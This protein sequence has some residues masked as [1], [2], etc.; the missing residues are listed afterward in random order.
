MM[1]IDATDAAGLRAVLR[2]DLDAI[3]RLEEH[4]ASLVQPA[5]EPLDRA[6]IDSLGFTLHN[7]YNALENSFTQ[8]SLSFENHIKD[9]VRWQRE[10]LDKMF[11]SIPPVRPAVLPPEVRPLLGDLLAFRHL[12]RHAY[13]LSLDEAKVIALAR[14]WRDEGGEVK[15][16]LQRFLEQLP[17][18]PS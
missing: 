18:L 5:G 8:L 3:A 9:R 15:E 4:V 13:E 16:A 7:L 1:Q 14:R 12:F 11:L 17:A 6:R 10:L 2:K